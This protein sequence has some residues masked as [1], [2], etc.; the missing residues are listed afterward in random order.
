MNIPS[1][2]I[3]RQND[4]LNAGPPLDRLCQFQVTPNTLFFVRNHGSVPQVDAAAYRLAVDGQVARPLTLSLDQLRD[5][6][7]QVTLTATLQCAGN[8]RQELMAVQPIPGELAWDAE[9]ISNATWRGTP[10]QQV[11]DA[12]GVETRPSQHVALTGLDETE[13]QGHCFN[14]GGSIPLDKALNPEVL[15]AYEMNGEPLTPL[16][17]YPLRLVVPGYIGARSVKWLSRITV[18]DAP[19]NNYFQAR[20]YKLFP[21]QARAENVDWDSGFMLGEMPVNAVICAPAPQIKLSAGPTWMRGYAL[22]GGNRQVARVDVSIDGGTNWS[23][24]EL[25]GEAQPWT[26]RLWRALVQFQPGDHELIVRAYDSAA[27]TQPEH[28]QSIWNFKGY[29]NNAWHRVHV[30]VL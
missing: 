11:L 8:R 3:V 27:N 24:A 30:Q 16:H 1:P 29:M 6:F 13:R 7:P 5:R 20:A 21:P 14:F 15:L 23:E 9:A 26:W 22:A 2:L 28:A 12:A 17:G 18:Q 10:L 4:P 19:S 25:L